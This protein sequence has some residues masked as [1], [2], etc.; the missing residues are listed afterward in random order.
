MSETAAAPTID[1]LLGPQDRQAALEHDV[2]EGLTAT[3]KRMPPKWHYDEEGSRLFSLI[4]E[5]PEYYL[6]R[7]EREILEAHADDIARESGADTLV[8]LGAGT[9]QKTRLLLDA[10]R[11]AGLLRRIVLLDVDEATLR[12]SAAALADEYAGVEVCGVVGDIQ[13]HL[14]ELPRGGRRMIAFLGSSI[15]NFLPEERAEFLAALYAVDGSRG[16]VLARR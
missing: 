10:M 4:T 1:V 7:R 13:R 2:R 11:D 16:D 8:E 3:P 5:L 12:M 14:G 9:S 6:T 15:G